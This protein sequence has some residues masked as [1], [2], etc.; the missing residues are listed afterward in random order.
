MFQAQSCPTLCDPMDHS[1]PCSS[2]HGILQARILEW[3]A[4]SFSRKSYPYRDWTPISCISRQ[5]LYHWATRE[6]HKKI[7]SAYKFIIIIIIFTENSLGLLSN[8]EKVILIFYQYNLLDW[9]FELN[10]IKQFVINVLFLVVHMN[11]T[12][13]SSTPL[14]HI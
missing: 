8:V 1:I 12:L 13:S 14:F 10:I 9:P 2:V 3:V 6:A 7:I 5:V 11:F 4:I